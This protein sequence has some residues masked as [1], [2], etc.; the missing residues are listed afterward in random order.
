[1]CYM[2]LVCLCACDAR[3]RMNVLKNLLIG[4]VEL[5]PRRRL[6]G[7][8]GSP[9]DGFFTRGGGRSVGGAG[10][11][12]DGEQLGGVGHGFVPSKTW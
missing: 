2:L 7:A 6:D 4:I 3:L 1:M 5:A 11:K 9:A 12:R 10:S 8:T